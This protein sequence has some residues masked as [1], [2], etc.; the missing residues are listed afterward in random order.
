[1]FVICYF[2]LAVDCCFRFGILLL[3][4]RVDGLYA[5]MFV[6]LDPGFWCVGLVFALLC[7]VG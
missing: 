4:F 7:V 1:M 3:I 6:G 2:V 5:A